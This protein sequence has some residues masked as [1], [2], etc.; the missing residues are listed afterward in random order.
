MQIRRRAL[1]TALTLLVAGCRALGDT[2][3]SSFGDECVSD[4]AIYGCVDI[5]GRVSTVGGAPL[6]NIDVG[7][8]AGSDLHGLKA[9]FVST[10]AD[11]EYELRLFQLDANA[12]SQFNLSLKAT[13]RDNAGAEV[14]SKVMTTQVQVYQVNDFPEPVTLNFVIQ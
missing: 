11:G 3:E 1:I 4:A 12:P 13:Q 8:A 5:Q 6:E 2:G 7:P 9:K 10:G 14:K